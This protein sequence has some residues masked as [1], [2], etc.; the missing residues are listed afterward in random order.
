[1]TNATKSA[2]KRK[3]QP[4]LEFFFLPSVIQNDYVLQVVQNKAWHCLKR[5]QKKVSLSIWPRESSSLPFP[6]DL[7]PSTEGWIK[8]IFSAGS[9]RSVFWCPHRDSFKV[10]HLFL[11]SIGSCGNTF[12]LSAAKYIRGPSVSQPASSFRHRSPAHAER[13]LEHFERFQ[14]QTVK[15]R[16]DGAKNI[17]VKEF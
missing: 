3:S 7:N 4:C 6:P 15:S 16:D 14:L 13:E 2:L 5:H 1:M 8:T 9:N 17:H 11:V 12:V 10:R